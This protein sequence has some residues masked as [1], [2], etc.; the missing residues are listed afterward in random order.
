MSESFYD[1]TVREA[2]AQGLPA[3]VAK[4]IADECTKDPGPKPARIKARI[5]D[6]RQQSKLLRMCGCPSLLPHF[7]RAGLDFAEVQA[8]LH[9]HACRGWV[10]TSHTEALREAAAAGRLKRVPA[11]S[12]RD[13][14]ASVYSSKGPAK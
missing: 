11:P 13:I 7:V 14:A 5:D 1:R 4:L 3:D 10:N 12:L 8:A 6:V 2:L 9:Q